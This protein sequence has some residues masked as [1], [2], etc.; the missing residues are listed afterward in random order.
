MELYNEEY[1]KKK[2]P[3]LSLI[4][5]ISI[6]VLII[7]SIGIIYGIIYIRGTI[8]NITLD[9]QKT[10][11]IEK[12][13]LV[14]ETAD[15]SELYIPIR[16]IAEYFNYE[17]YNGDYKYKSEDTSKCYVKNEDEIAMFTLDSS[18]L[19][20]TRGNSDYEY[21]D[22]DKKVFEKDGDLYTTIDGIE[23]AF[24]VKIFY[25]PE[26]KNI[27]IYTMDYLVEWSTTNLNIT[28]YSTV[29]SD[30]KAI[31]ENM[32]IVKRNDQYG[33]IDSLNGEAILETKYSSIKYV[34]N[35]KDFIVESDGRFGVIDK[36]ANIK[37]KII[38]DEIKMMDNE[39]ELYLLKENNLYGVA[40]INGNVIVEPQYQQIGINIERFT[41]NG[42]ESQYILADS[43]IPIKNNNLWGFF[44]LTGKQ[45]TDFIYTD[46]GCTSSTLSNSY[47]VLTIPSYK[48]IVV[49][50]G[51]FYNLMRLNGKNLFLS[52]IIDS[53]YMKTTAATGENSYYM[54]YNGKTE[55]IEERLL[56][57]GVKNETEEN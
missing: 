11:S 50:E 57:L 42:I 22:L 48:M 4:I 6:V 36:S 15:G 20:K 41:Q 19:V 17:D 53:I 9:G 31:F 38:Y 40:D 55:N 16:K 56:E 7:I 49:R 13:L 35:T 39:N 54:T 21:I 5:I 52:G 33:V 10:N 30:K 25:K 43:L 1:N 26:S 37:I 46:L 8:T 34:P 45:V 3:Q 27:D 51:E 29:F 12:I 24:N 44:D 32:I 23:K 47:P 28:D 18:V 14:Q 2:K